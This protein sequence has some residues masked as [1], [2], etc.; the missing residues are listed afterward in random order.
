MKPTLRKP[1]GKRSGH[2]TPVA[3]SVAELA[4]FKIQ[5]EDDNDTDDAAEDE[6]EDIKPTGKLTRSP[7][8]RR[9][10]PV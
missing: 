7:S 5:G 10:K 3:S 6:S 1:S 4:M 9:F 2:A 8:V